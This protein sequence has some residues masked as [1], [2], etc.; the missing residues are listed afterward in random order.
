MAVKRFIFSYLTATPVRDKKGLVCWSR[1]YLS[2]EWG[3][4]N[5]LTLSTKLLSVSCDVGEMAHLDDQQET[6]V[7]YVMQNFHC[8]FN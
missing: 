1:S 8:Y 2:L 4:F 7:I 6:N 5:W 3:Q